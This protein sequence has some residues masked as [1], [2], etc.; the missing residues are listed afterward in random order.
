MDLVDSLLDAETFTKL[1]LRN[2]YSNLWVAEGNKDKLAFICRSGQFA[3][4]TMPFGP[5]GAPGYFQYFMKDI[6]LGCIGKDVA[7]Y[8]D[9]I[10]IYTKKGSNHKYAVYTVLDNLRNHTPG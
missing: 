10:M 4:L 6:L 9:N 7:A 8:L 5:T 1:D 2:A 3:P